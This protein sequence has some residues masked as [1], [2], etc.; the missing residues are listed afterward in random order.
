MDD[1]ELQ[2]LLSHPTRGAWIEIDTEWQMKES[3]PSRTPHGVRGLK[4]DCGEQDQ[5]APPSRTP[6][7]VRGLKLFHGRLR[8]PI[9]RRTPH[10]VRGLKFLPPRPKLFDPGSHPTRGAWIEISPCV[11]VRWWTTPSH[12]TR[13][14]WIEIPL[15]PCGPAGP[16]V[17]PHTGCVD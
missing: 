1:P 16:W 15:G 14:A 10:G 13:G 11:L 4:L 8:H 5:E 6:H 3:C 9:H 2:K 17:A 7:G 12:P